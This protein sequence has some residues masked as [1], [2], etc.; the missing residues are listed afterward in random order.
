MKA[1][2]LIVD[3]QPDIRKLIRITLEEKFD[4]LESEDGENALD[5]I[6]RQHP[7]IVILDV[8]L[9]GKVDGFNVL[10]TIKSNPK[11]AAIKVIMLTARCQK[12]DFEIG[13]LYG[14]DKYFVKP[15][16]PLLLAKI[17][18]EMADTPQSSTCLE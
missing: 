4:I 5:F 13:A 3:D 1:K 11:L 18:D 12:Q 9:K 7:S 14:A 6:E 15:F 2:I 8:K 16:S 10:R 17:V